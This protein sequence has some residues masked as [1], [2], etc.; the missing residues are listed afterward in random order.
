MNKQQTRSLGTTHL[1]AER[2]GSSLPSL[3]KFAH[4]KVVII[5]WIGNVNKP[6]RAVQFWTEYPM[7]MS[8]SA[9][10]R[11]L[12]VRLGVGWLGIC[13]WLSWA[14]WTSTKPCSCPF[15]HPLTANSRSW[16]LLEGLWDPHVKIAPEDP[17]TLLESDAQTQQNLEGW[18]SLAQGAKTRLC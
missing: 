17:G 3:Q 11:G 8:K 7:I 15:L 10:H 6:S 16:L 13:F 9:C 18:F 12:N 2:S 5:P 1:Y 4:I 14:R